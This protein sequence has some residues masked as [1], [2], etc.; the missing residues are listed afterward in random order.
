MD[1]PTR[2]TSIYV[3]GRF[4]LDAARRRLTHDGQPVALT[5]TVFDLLLYLVANAGRVVPKDELFEAVWPGRAL[6]DSNLTTSIFV[7]RRALKGVGE[8]DRLIAT[9]PG[10]GYMFAIAVSEDPV[11]PPPEG[12]RF[13]QGY[14]FAQPARLQMQGAALDA[15]PEIVPRPSAAHLSRDAE[16][17]RPI[18]S[19]PPRRRLPV[20]LAAAAAALVAIAVCVWLWRGHAM[21]P[22]RVVVM[23]EFLNLTREPLFDQTF[24]EATRA[25]LQQSPFL[26][27]LPEQRVQD[28]L[29]LMTRP[30]DERLT[31]AVSEEVCARDN[32]LAA[33]HGSL[34]QVG[35]RYL[36]TLTAYDC[37]SGETMAAEKAEVSGRDGLLPALDALAG[38]LRRRL[39]ESASSLRAFST[40]IARA[41]TGSFEALK[42]YSQARY[43]FEHG[44][45]TE[46][47]ALFRQA[48]ELDPNFAQAHA[49][50]ASVLYNLRENAEA[51][52]QITQARRLADPLAPRV[53]LEIEYRYN[54]IVTQDTDE[55]IRVL[56]SWTEIYPEEWRPWAN[57]ANAETWRGE[58][59]AAIGPGRRAVALEP[60]VE[61]AYVVLAR[62]YLHAGRYAEARAVCDAGVAHK[63]DGDDLHG[64]AYQ[65]AVA[66]GDAGGAAREMQWAR[67]KPGERS[68]LIEAGQDAF[69]LGQVRR[70]QALFGEAEALG[71]SLGLSDTMSAANARLLYDMGLT[72]LAR[73]TLARV[74]A[75]HD[76]TD[77]RFSLAEFGDAARAQSLLSADLAK[78]PTDTFLTQ[79]FAPEVRAALALRAGRP[80]D[81]VEALRPALPYDDAHSFDTPYL[82]GIAYLAAGDGAGAAGE[83]R[84]ILDHPGVEPLSVHYPL[85]H[86][87][88]ARAEA[89]RRDTA[90]ARRAYEAFFADWKDADP[91]MPLLRQARAEYARLPRPA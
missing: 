17:Q 86:L 67:G 59:L 14:S 73:E 76:S 42:A 49:D 38:R 7:L 64:V 83:F 80:R 28:T 69:R 91:D 75:D 45:R 53:R 77:T 48:I 52:S 43:D 32:G 10:R 68:M 9:A 87:G 8:S 1:R 27:V 21:P 89:L 31:P 65:I 6:D 60:G 35:P 46:A 72:D 3:F 5:P 84:K 23:G 40:P 63:V 26:S 47:V 79:V 39:G 44:R 88:L 30:K 4:R 90:A 18:T 22:R 74:P 13:G 66:R 82:R 33:V 24:D 55:G 81:A 54:L 36:L 85:S 12:A 56:K 34:S 62:A 20:V 58:P 2:Q 61:G 51:A 15:S 37:V 57:L 19:G 70:A 50:L 78:A 25:E 29:A 71:R 11:E 16:E 41:R